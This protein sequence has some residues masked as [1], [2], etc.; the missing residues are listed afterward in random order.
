[1]AT[2]PR[3]KEEATSTCTQML[4][5]L[6]SPE[7]NSSPPQ[8]PAEMSH[9]T[10]NPIHPT[11]VLLCA[12]PK[13]NFC[14]FSSSPMADLVGKSTLCVGCVM[15]QFDCAFVSKTL[16]L[17]VNCSAD[18]SLSLLLTVCIIQVRNGQKRRGVEISKSKPSVSSKP[19]TNLLTEAILQRG[20]KPESSDKLHM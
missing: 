18:A 14:T 6:V 2:V 7:E 5:N 3:L 8:P 13:G 19:Q 16:T 9:C 20:L 12:I 1:M 11:Y 10:P 17:P 15:F 4:G